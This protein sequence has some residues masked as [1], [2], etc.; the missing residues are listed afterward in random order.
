MKKAFSLVMTILLSIN[1]LIASKARAEGDSFTQKDRELLIR[2]DERLNQIDKR[3]EQINKRIED[4]RTDMNKRFELQNKRIEELR[5]DMNK[6]FEQIDKRFEQ[7]D[8][9]FE[10]I[11]K[12]FEQVNKRF[13]EQNKRFDEQ[14][15]RFDTIQQLMIAIIA[16]FAAIVAVAI[17]FA[18]WDRSTM[19]RKARD[20]A[21]ERIEKEGR[22]RDLIRAL[23]RYA[24]K[25][26]E[27][28]ELLR[29]FNLL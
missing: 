29:S 2:L 6:R 3:F 26:Q 24:K 25:D 17:G 14:N 28:A 18:I 12:R 9:R 8:K 4:L 1:G 11:D 5:E 15:K 16:A 10:Q 23:R 22:L 27:L 7:V 19:V 21:I 20:E 13:E